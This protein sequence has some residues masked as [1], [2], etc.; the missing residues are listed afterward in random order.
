MKP[1]ALIPVIKREHQIILK[2]LEE[3]SSNVRLE[4]LEW[5]MSAIEGEHHSKEE[6]LI[7]KYLLGVEKVKQGGPMCGLYFDF[8]QMNRPEDLLKKKNLIFQPKPNQEIFF[9]ES[10][11]LQIP[12]SEHIA[13]RVILADMIEKFN[14]MDAKQVKA[15]FS[16]YIELN[17]AHFQKEENCFFEMLGH[18]L[19]PTVFDSLLETWLNSTEYFK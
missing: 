11:P 19:S 3:F 15:R 6:N 4:D 5:C 18:V 16:E 9:K 14:G 2:K 12:V 1:H 7:F 17:Q 8:F 13:T 10:H